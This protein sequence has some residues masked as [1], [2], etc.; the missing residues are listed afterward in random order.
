MLVKIKYFLL[1]IGCLVAGMA[2]AQ[3]PP[4]S[5]L[6][7]NNVRATILGDGTCLYPEGENASC[8]I[9]E[10]P[11]GGSAGTMRQH[12]LWFGGMAGNSLHLSAMRLGDEGRDYWSGPLK[13]G[14]AS[15]DL[16]ASLKFNRIWKITRQE[17]EQFI[18]NHGNASYVAPV[19]ILSWP[20]QGGS[21]YADN[22]APFVDVNADGLYNPT[23][24]D[25]PDIRGDQCL[26]FIFNDSYGDHSETGGSKV[27]LEVH[28]MVYGYDAPGDEALNNT[29]F[30]N[31]KIF[32]RSAN[33]YHDAYVGLWNDWS[34]GSANDDYIGCDVQRNAC[35]AY[36]GT[37]I[38][39]DGGQGT[40]GDHSP[41]QVL[42]VLNSPDGL[43][44]TGFLSHNDDI[45]PMGNPENALEYYYLLQGRWRD[46]NVIQYGGNGYPGGEGVVGPACHYMFPGDSDPDNVGTGG[47]DPNGGYNV[48]GIYWTEANENNMP[49]HR[50]GLV[51]V[52]PFDFP[53]G[54]MKELDYAM[55]T[56]WKN[57]NQS[58]MERRT[59]YIDHVRAFYAGHVDKKIKFVK[60]GILL[61]M[62]S[63]LSEENDII[64]TMQQFNANLTFDKF[65][66]G[67]RQLSDEALAVEDNLVRNIYDMTAPIGISTFWALYAQHGWTIPRMV[68]PSQTLDDNDVGSVWVDQNNRRFLI[69]K[70][71]DTEIY[72]LP[73]I[74]LGQN[75]VYSSSWNNNLEY[76]SILTHVSGAVHTG[77]IEGTSSRFDLTSQQFEN[78]RFILDGV[79]ITDDGVYYC[80]QLRIQEHIRGLN[81]GKVETWFPVPEYNGSLVEFDRSFVFDNGMNVTCNTT[82]SCKH[83]FILTSYRG[84]QP[85]FPLQKDQYHSYSFI[86][87]VKKTSNGHRIDIPFDSDNGIPSQIIISRIPSHLYDVDKQPERCVTYLMNNEGSFLVG[88]AGGCSLTRGLSVDSVRNVNVHIGRN[89]V[90]YGG[91]GTVANKFYPKLL[92]TESFDGPVD[93][94]F[95][96]EMS[97]YFSWFDPNSNDCLVY[98]YKDEDSY[99]VY[100]HTFESMP[101]VEI[102]LP[103]HL[104]GMVVDGVIEKTAGSSL[105]T[106]QVVGGKL[107]ASFNTEKGIA[108][109]IVLR[110]K[111]TWN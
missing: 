55:T 74:T 97:G 111:S 46:G 84:I 70:V 30:V 90:T 33:N 20:A 102:H 104:E 48:N 69:G 72:L 34:I 73:E 47:T 36:N 52:G 75:G 4:I 81:I 25:Y 93:T 26:F 16:M 107:L 19:D 37:P 10:V 66:V 99:I 12:A 15:I 49:G 76:P 96:A 77:V 24:G 11:D 86:P 22:L 64:V 43:G 8:P 42:T 91:D 58:A 53:S 94:T 68:V 108:N 67:S 21:G 27:G 13:T 78:R 14:D 40:Y 60:N 61:S 6:D 85:Q 71:S 31:Y 5:Q 87:K 9:W 88:M 32:N 57:S 51:S 105:L 2:R 41:V 38:D 79:D 92:D 101:K 95:V 80:N 62:R 3:Y 44:M 63:R 106:E 100:V 17:I 110:L 65:Y 1:I 103:E 28:A 89:N 59:A 50:S 18:A 82:L 35:Y 54:C 29:V 109:Y 7:I 45:S 83:P 23:D 39:G 98:Y 56:V